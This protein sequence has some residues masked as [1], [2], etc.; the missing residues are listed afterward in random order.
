MHLDWGGVHVDRL[1]PSALSL[2]RLR[3]TRTSKCSEKEITDYET[4]RSEPP[5]LSRQARDL[6]ACALWNPDVFRQRLR[7]RAAVLFCRQ[8]APCSAIHSQQIRHHLSSYGQ[9]RSIRIS[10][11]LFG[12][13]DERQ[14]MILSRCQLGGFHQHSLDMLLRCLESGVRITLSAELFSSPHSPQ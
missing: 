11:L 14:F 6:A 12:F 2:D 13:I 4:I 1:L 5:S 7:C 10:F 3:L 8:E 9:R